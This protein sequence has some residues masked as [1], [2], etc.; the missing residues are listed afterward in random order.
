MSRKIIGVTVGTPISAS[1]LEDKLKPVKTING[2]SPDV[3][4]NV[5]VEGGLTD[6]A[7]ALLITILRNAVYTSDQSA[8][9]TALETAL[10]SSGSG[11][12]GETEE[13]TITQTG[14]VLTIVGVDGITSITQTG[15]V[16]SLT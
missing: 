7:R 6:T 12:S 13:I 16:L 9:I 4:G 5:E 1:S 14:T 8:N 10:A 11:D 3:N 15:T 2:V